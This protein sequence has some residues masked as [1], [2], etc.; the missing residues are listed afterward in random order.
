MQC[1]KAKKEGKA[2]WWS[3]FL[4]EMQHFRVVGARGIDLPPSDLGRLGTFYGVIV[5][6]LT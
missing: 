4:H 6:E 2:G 1:F 5:T 3:R